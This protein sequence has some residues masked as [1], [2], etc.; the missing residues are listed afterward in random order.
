[1]PSVIMLCVTIKSTI[2]CVVMLNVIM[3]N[4][5]APFY[6]N[7]IGKKDYTVACIHQLQQLNMLRSYMFYNNGH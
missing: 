7:K 5:V 2:L 1:M 3:P 4:V 6:L